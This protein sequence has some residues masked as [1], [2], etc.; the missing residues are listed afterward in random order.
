M[1]TRHVDQNYTKRD[2]E[3]HGGTFDGRATTVW[4]NQKEDGTV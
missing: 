3:S 2:S 1:K 4:N